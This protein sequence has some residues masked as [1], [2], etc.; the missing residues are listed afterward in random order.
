[1]VFVVE[2]PTAHRK[3]CSNAQA[4]KLSP[5][6][7]KRWLALVGAG[8]LLALLPWWLG[9]PL[10][11]A[12]MTALPLLQSR[13]LPA[14]EGFL[15]GALRWALAGWLLA[16][17]WE[18]GGGAMAWLAA[19]LG[20][21]AG[22]TLLAGLDAWLDRDLRREAVAPPPAEWPASMLDADPSADALQA[23]SII[24]L[25]APQWCGVDEAATASF[26]ALATWH[27]DGYCL[28]DG[29]QLMNVQ[30]QACCSDDGRWFVA[31]IDPPEGVALWNVER[32]RLHRLGGWQLCG[33]YRDQPWL[34]RDEQDVPVPLSTVLA[35]VRA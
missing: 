35:Q 13:L 25:E 19:L 2:R 8:L 12:L 3:R 27:G 5:P 33:W 18:L 11:L 24:E 15:R 31:R 1:M 16:L 34:Q 28:A 26:S 29:T 23:D 20:A 10:L 6:W 21:L 14:Q 17:L 30:C 32:R 22:C 9:L 7:S 4:M